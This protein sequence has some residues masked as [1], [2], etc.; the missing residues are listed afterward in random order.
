MKHKCQY[1]TLTV[2]AA[3]HGWIVKE[4]GKPDEVFMRWESVVIRLK[5]ELTSSG[6]GN[7]DGDAS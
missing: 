1:K 3:I 4:H 7:R 6:D 5:N 2:T